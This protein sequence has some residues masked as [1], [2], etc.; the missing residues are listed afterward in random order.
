MACSPDEQNPVDGLTGDRIGESGPHQGHPGKIQT[1]GMFRKG[2]AQDHVLHIALFHSRGTGNHFIK[3][4]GRHVI[5]TD[6]NQGP[7]FGPA[8]SRP[9]SGNDPDFFYHSS[10]LIS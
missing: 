6:V 9:G 5:G 1:L 3:Y 7:S 4:G 2:T 8:Y 10:S